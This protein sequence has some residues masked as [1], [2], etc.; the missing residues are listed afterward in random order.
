[1]FQIDTSLLV[2]IASVAAVVLGIGLLAA[3]VDH[4][5]KGKLQQQQMLLDTALENMSQGLPCSMLTA[6]SCCAMSITPR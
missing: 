4:Q 2:V 3:L 6:A 1:M 5:S